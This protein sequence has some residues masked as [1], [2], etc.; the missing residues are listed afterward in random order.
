MN[1]FT[2]LRLLFS[3]LLLS[4]VL[5][6]CATVEGST[7]PEDPFESFNR[8]MYSFNTTVD[9]A[10]LKPA[11]EGYNAVLPDPV[12][13]GISNFFS[14]LNDVV[15]IFNDLL[16]LKLEQGIHDTARVFFNTTIGLLGFFDVASAMELPKHN[17]DLGQSLGYWGVN[18]GPYLVLPLL[19]PSNIRDT[20]GLIG[21]AYVD[22][23]NDINPDDTRT[24]LIVLNVVDTRAGLLSASKV[25]QEAA[26][27]EYLFTRDAYLQRRQ[28][29]VYDGNPPKPS[30]D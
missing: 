11:A 5:Q 20:V 27:D 21:D 16:Q 4:L 7:D 10:I 8:A 1:T 2:R 26:L 25:L 9:K 19:G 24:G 12:N 13:K 3:V 17:E 30:F 28:N 22:P 14:N 29:L 6:G 15:I 18:T 23:V